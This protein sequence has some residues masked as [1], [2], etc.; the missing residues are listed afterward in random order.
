[1]ESHQ[2]VDRH[3][4][5]R[6]AGHAANRHINI[7]FCLAGLLEFG[8]ADWLGMRGGGIRSSLSCLHTSQHTVLWPFGLNFFSTIDAPPG[9]P[10]VSKDRPASVELEFGGLVHKD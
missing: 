4:R 7:S 1:M 8:G 3:T 10:G 5:L 6:L 2:H 9:V